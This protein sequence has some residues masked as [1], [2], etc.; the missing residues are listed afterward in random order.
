MLIVILLAAGFLFL[1][2]DGLGDGGFAIPGYECEK[3][4]LGMGEDLYV[5]AVGRYAGAYVE[6][7]S[8]EDV[9]NVLAVVLE[10]RGDSD[11]QLARFSLEAEEKAYSFEAVTVP[12]GSKTLVMEKTAAPWEK[13]ESMNAEL[14]TCAYFQTEMSLYPEQFEITTSEQE[15][16]IKNIGD[17]VPSG[18]HVYYKNRINDMYLGGI[19]YRVGTTEG[20]DSGENINFMS[21]HYTQDSEIVFVTY[22]Y[23]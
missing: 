3:T 13:M 8:D 2:D 14:Q 18:V 4:E 17:T 23:E 7:G 19:T 12:A 9:E 6:D 21:N 22:A 15:I 10:N 11:V 5:I 20:L 16:A 1:R